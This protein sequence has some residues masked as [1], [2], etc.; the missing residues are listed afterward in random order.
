MHFDGHYPTKF[1]CDWV[2][3]PGQYAIEAIARLTILRGEA[4]VEANARLTILRSQV[5]IEVITR[6]SIQP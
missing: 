1:W 2:I 6:Q 3:P 5:T 4:A